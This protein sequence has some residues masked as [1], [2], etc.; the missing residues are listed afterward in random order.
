M[1]LI[2]LFC[3]LLL[4]LAPVSAQNLNLASFQMVWDTVNTKHWDLAGTGV[5]WAKVYETYKPR[6]EAAGGIVETRKILSEMLAELGQS[7][8]NIMQAN[9]SRELDELSNTYVLGSGEPGFV[10]EVVEG[11]VFIVHI[12]E[13]SRKLMVGSEIV[14]LRGDDMGEILQ[15]IF[16]AYEDSTH[17]DLYVRRM[18]NSFFCGP[19]GK[20]LPLA[21]VTRGKRMEVKAPLSVPKG[22]TLNLMNLNGLHYRY[23]SEMLEGNIAYVHFNVFVPNVKP[24]F[25]RDMIGVFR[26]ADGLVLDLRGNPGG[27]APYALSVASRLVSEK[28]KKL[29]EMKNPGGTMNFPIFPQQPVFEKPVAILIDS[30]SASTSEILAQGLQDLGRARVFGYR[31]AGAALPSLVVD[32]PNGDKFQYA[33][34]DYVSF[35]GHHL[36]G[37]GVTPDE[38]APHTLEALA[39]GE[40]AAQTAAIKWIKLQQGAKHENL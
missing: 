29:G 34:A 14:G 33:V 20:K 24:D 4:F 3:A 2:V 35:K 26:H 30:G 17:K 19:V 37:S 23:D 38:A 13:P 12:D 16:K 32:L 18:L 5:D 15:R 9:A 8:F 31:S 22:I 11:R 40:D 25:D 28:G 36:E 10:V 6:V 1:R 27:L 39:R 7:H 21:V